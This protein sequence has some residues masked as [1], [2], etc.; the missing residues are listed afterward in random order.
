MLFPIA[1]CSRRDL[2]PGQRRSPSDK[3]GAETP[4]K[5]IT[6]RDCSCP[7]GQSYYLIDLNFL[8]ERALSLTTRLQEH[9]FVNL[10]N[11]LNVLN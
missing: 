11:L 8:L 6:A 2:N 10:L 5:G 1:L 4:K 7:R 3:S 9:Y